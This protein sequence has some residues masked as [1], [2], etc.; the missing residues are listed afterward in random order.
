MRDLLATAWIAVGEHDA[1]I[2]PEWAMHCGALAL[3]DRYKDHY[4]PHMRKR[5]GQSATYQSVRRAKRKFY[6]KRV[7]AHPPPMC[8]NGG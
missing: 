1:N 5:W 7:N 4:R 2:A 8:D 6:L 3:I